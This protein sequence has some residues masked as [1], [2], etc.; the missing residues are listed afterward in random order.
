M[1]GRELISSWPGL[2]EADAVTL[3]ASPAWRLLVDFN[4]DECRVTRT[5]AAA[6]EL[7]LKVTFDDEPG[8]L[9]I[10]DSET[11]SDLHLLWARLSELPESLVIALVEKE[12]GPLL[13]TIENIVR[14]E[15]RIVGVALGE[16][17]ASS[18]ARTGFILH[19]G[20]Y[21]L[22]FSLPLSS[23]T[24]R[25][26]GVLDN[27]DT[28]H[29]TIRAL[30]RPVRAQ[31]AVMDLSPDQ[32]AAIKE[33][34]FLVDSNELNGVWQ[35]ELPND[36]ALRLRAESD[37]GFTF[38]EFADDALPVVPPAGNFAVYSRGKRIASAELAK[39]GDIVGY[40]IISVS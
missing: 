17:A 28:E 5:D 18:G 22:G 3:L 19:D 40:R 27:L 2:A 33:G 29:E 9:G 20:T 8:V 30:T 38:A 7:L 16:T 21:E 34:D 13:Q 37:V 1:D 39:V 25:R 14:K 23:D 26:L 35:T 36:D 32:I 24:V 6:R 11:F 15:L 10:S 4:G 12:V 31:Y